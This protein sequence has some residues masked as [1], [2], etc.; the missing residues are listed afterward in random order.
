MDFLNTK[1]GTITGLDIQYNVDGWG[2]KLG[3]K[4]GMFDSVP[5]AHF[6]KKEKCGRPADFTQGTQPYHQRSYQ[7]YRQKGDDASGLNADFVYRHDNVEDQSFQLVDTSKTQ[8]RNKFGAKRTW[9]PQAGRDAG[10]G[11]RGAPGRSVGGRTSTRPGGRPEPTPVPVTTGRGG[12]AGGRMKQG[13]R[14]G[15]GGRGRTNNRR[16][17]RKFDRQPS[18]T[19]QGDWEVIEEFDLVQF[20]KLQANKPEV[21]DLLWCGHVDQYDDSYDKITSKAPKPLRRIE[22]KAYY[23]VSSTD[24]PILEKF[25]VER[26]GNLY[27]TD[28]ILAH[29]MACPRSVYSWDIVIQKTDGM[30]FFDKRD[31]SHFDLLTVSETAHEPPTAADDLDEI[32]HPEKLSLE[33]TMINQNFSQQ[34]VKEGTESRKTYEPNPFF[35]KG[36]E[37]DVEPASIAYRYRKFKLGDVTIIARCELH[38]WAIK[39]GEEQF[40]TVHAL[41]EWDS[42]YSGGVEWRQKIDQQRGA[43][44]ATELKNNSSKFAKWTAQSILAGADLMKL[45]YVS[46]VS[47]TNAYEHT[48]LGA[49]FLKPTELATQIALSVTNMWGIIKMLA[50]LLMNQEDGK[51]VLLKDPNKGTVRLYSVPVSTFE[52]D[53]EEAVGDGDD[54][55]DED[56]DDA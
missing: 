11:G 28:A 43:V 16:M 29:L 47:K 5:Y 4:F 2:P 6:D 14:G 38:G 35:E 44:L 52:S 39:R 15:R 8:S 21:E 41:N 34:V 48:I 9:T 46:R 53:E 25:A 24:D 19:V 49:Q 12:R 33:A 20:L 45:G 23:C 51:Y 42:R 13:A 56:D 22:N 17:D 55:E 31:D 32:N 1:S 36:V 37:K 50:D 30:L 54:E 10:R 40:M 26:A 7:R 3:E 27:A 18:L